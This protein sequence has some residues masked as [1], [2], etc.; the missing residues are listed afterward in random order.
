VSADP[1]AA[2]SALRQVE[3]VVRAGRA[4]ER[5]T[6]MEA[7]GMRMATRRP[8]SRSPDDDLQ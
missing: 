7:L 2:T 5:G 1:L 8:A 6:L 3:V 4:Y